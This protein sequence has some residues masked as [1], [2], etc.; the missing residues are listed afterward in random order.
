MSL[1]LCT[2]RSTR[3]SSSSRREG[4]PDNRAQARREH[5]APAQAER[6]AAPPRPDEDATTRA[7]RPGGAAHRHLPDAP[8]AG[9]RAAQQAHRHGAATAPACCACG[10]L[11]TVL[12]L[13]CVSRYYVKSTV[14]F[15]ARYA[16]RHLALRASR[17]RRGRGPWPVRVPLSRHSSSLDPLSIVPMR[18]HRPNDTIINMTHT[19]ILTLTSL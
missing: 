8:L 4:N 17:A 9:A 6:V 19:H 12:M 3:A 18:P 7:A 10:Q 11:S 16:S 15:T 5:P 1:W 13:V 2:P 14:C